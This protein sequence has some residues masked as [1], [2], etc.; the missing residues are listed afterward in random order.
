MKPGRIPIALKAAS[1]YLLVVIAVLLWYER[2]LGTEN[3][4][5]VSGLVLALITLPG[6]LYG[7]SFAHLFNCPLYSTCEHV[8]GAIFAGGLNAILI[9]VVVHTISRFGKA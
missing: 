6:A 9:F 2:S 7:R 3:G 1:T 5:M 4:G 8:S